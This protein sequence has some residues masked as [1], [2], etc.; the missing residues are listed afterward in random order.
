M[1][2][3]EIQLEDE[4]PALVV[5]FI[6]TAHDLRPH[7]GRVYRAIMHY[8]GESGED[9][10]GFAFAVYRNLDMEYLDVEA[11]YLV[12]KLLP[13][14][15][16]IRP[17]QISGGRFAV[18]HYSGPSDQSE[19]AYDL[20]ADFAK[21]RG[22]ALSGPAYEWYLDDPL[23]PL[24]KSRIDIAVPVIRLEERAAV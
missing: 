5:R 7:C 3:C 16:E 10:A 19:A 9:Q 23:V 21:A 14:K 13:A 18:C 22:Y 8:L 20:L 6:A 11:G 15:G 24:E 12:R 1:F 4:Q 17:T 2:P